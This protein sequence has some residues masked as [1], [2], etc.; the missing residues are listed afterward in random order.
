MSNPAL[1]KYRLTLRNLVSPDKTRVKT[2]EAA[3]ENAAYAIGDAE[4]GWEV[5]GVSDMGPATSAFSLT[6]FQKKTNSFPDKDLIRF[7]KGMAT[8]LKAGISTV[9]SLNFYAGNLPQKHLQAVL[10]KIS[11]EIEMGEHPDVAFAR[12]G[13]FSNVFV[14]LVKAGVASGDLGGALDSIAHQMSVLATFRSKLKRIITVPICVLIFLLL[15]FMAAQNIITPRIEKMLA[16]NRAVP[17][18]FSAAIFTMSHVVQAVWLYVIFAIVGVVLLFILRKGV[19]DGAVNFLMSKWRLLRVVIMSMRQLTFIGTLNMM[20]G[21]K[22]PMEES[23]RICVLVLKGTAMAAEVEQARTQYLSGIDVSE[24]VRRYTSCEPTVVHMLA[25]GEKTASL[26]AQLQLCT[27]MLEDQAREA[28]ED[29]ASVTGAISTILP[30]FVIGF[31]FISS[32]LPIVL[33]SARLMQ[34]FSGR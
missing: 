11:H 29:F 15:L 4:K 5:T 6:L 1:R 16:A 8:M 20:V 2:V 12:T 17:D 18:A 23:L 21:N 3:A 34:S 28:M 27:T 9:D 22:I 26:P 33:M 25:I 32:Y 10:R 24:C 7:C 14:G 13:M 31:T 30:V 19:R